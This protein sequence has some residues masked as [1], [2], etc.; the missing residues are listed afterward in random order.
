MA[1]EIEEWCPELVTTGFVAERCG[2]SNATVL[3]WI[4]KGRLPAFRLPEGHFRIH[5]ECLIDFLTRY[6]IP[7]PHNLSRTKNI[8]INKGSSEKT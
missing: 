4:G 5:R 3:R 7:V 2:V 6:E 8:P 1:K